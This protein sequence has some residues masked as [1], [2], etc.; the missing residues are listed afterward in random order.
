MHNNASNA[1]LRIITFILRS[2]F[3]SSADSTHY[4]RRHIVSNLPQKAT[5]DLS[6][7]TIAQIQMI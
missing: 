3:N 6:P 5:D 1:Q 2:Y 7:Q 4:P